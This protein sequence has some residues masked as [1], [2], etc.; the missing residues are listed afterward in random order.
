MWEGKPT[1]AQSQQVRIQMGARASAAQVVSL[2]LLPIQRGIRVVVR[3]QARAYE[4]AH[5][6]RL[7]MQMAI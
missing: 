5:V 3:T 1:A 6:A 4:A 2:A 7:L